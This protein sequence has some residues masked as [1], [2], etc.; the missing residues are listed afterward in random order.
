MPQGPIPVST[1]AG[2]TQDLLA[3]GAAAVV[4]AG[5]GRIAKVVIVSPGTTSGAF[6]I[7]DS[8]TIGGANAANTVWTLP[9][10]A[11]SNVAGAVFNLDWPVNNGIVVSAVP[12]GGSPVI[13]VSFT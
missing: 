7:N 10:N 2:G 11:T 5:P 9:Y 1:G 8:A 12:G 6:T 13:N 3:I 4:K